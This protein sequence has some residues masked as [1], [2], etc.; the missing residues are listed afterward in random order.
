MMRTKY[1][2]TVEPTFV[3]RAARPLVCTD[4]TAL[5]YSYDCLTASYDTADAVVMSAV[6]RYEL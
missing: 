2:L 4:F 3:C 5:V 1:Y 6:A